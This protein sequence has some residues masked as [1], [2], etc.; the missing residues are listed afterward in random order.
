MNKDTIIKVHNNSN[1]KYNLNDKRN[2]HRQ[3]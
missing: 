1:R 2:Q 3:Q